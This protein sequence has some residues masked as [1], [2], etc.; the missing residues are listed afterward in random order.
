M[1]AADPKLIAAHVSAELRAGRR[2]PAERGE[3]D[4]APK[5]SVQRDVVAGALASVAFRWGTS[6]A[7]AAVTAQV[8]PPPK[9]APAEGTV[10]FCV[11]T[12]SLAEPVTPASRE[13]QLT[14]SRVTGRFLASVFADAVD[15]S[16][17][18]IR[19]GE[20]CWG[21]KV[22]V[23]IMELDGDAAELCVAAAAAALQRVAV[24]AATIVDGSETDEAV[25][26]LGRRPAAVCVGL[27]PDGALVASPNNVEL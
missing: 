13:S 20:A 7:I 9:D 14:R 10:E 24:P 23:R 12:S 15:K 22:D 17:L 3:F 19:A 26:A 1:Q 18:C 21:L 2:V 5:V 8:G 6:V 4:A 11:T 25:I 27:G 16:R